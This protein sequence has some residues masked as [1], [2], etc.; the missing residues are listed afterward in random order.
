M[1]TVVQ[2]SPDCVQPPQC[3]Q[4]LHRRRECNSTYWMIPARQ[5]D[6]RLPFKYFDWSKNP[7]CSSRFLRYPFCS[8]DSP[9]TE[10]STGPFSD[11][12]TRSFIYPSSCSVLLPKATSLS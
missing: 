12:S 7:L 11:S 3:C 8:L 10:P 5:A 4:N 1:T 2:A 9:S 6:K